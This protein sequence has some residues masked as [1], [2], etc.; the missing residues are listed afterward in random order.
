MRHQ[1]LLGLELIRTELTPVVAREMLVLAGNQV[2]TTYTAP[3]VDRFHQSL[4]SSL[5]LCITTIRN[6]FER[7]PSTNQVLS[8]LHPREQQWV[9]AAQK[10]LE[11]KE[12]S[13]M[14]SAP[15]LTS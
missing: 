3:V 4:L 2:N 1:V 12:R 8:S 14:A 6:R 10:F 15:A 5:D 9:R 11:Q 13:S 7:E